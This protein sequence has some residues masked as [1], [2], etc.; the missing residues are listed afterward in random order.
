[1]FYLF[2]ILQYHD[3]MEQEVPGV[4]PGGQLSYHKGEGCGSGAPARG[5]E[6]GLGWGGLQ[7]ALEGGSLIFW[8]LSCE[9][10]FVVVKNEFI[11]LF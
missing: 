1:M 9:G 4:W 8:V 7:R 6:R 11:Y 10:F 3:V 5:R 2:P